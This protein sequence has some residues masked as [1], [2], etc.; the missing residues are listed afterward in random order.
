MKYKVGDKL[1]LKIFKNKI[2]LKTE[3]LKKEEYIEDEFIIVAINDKLKYYTIIIHDNMYGWIINKFHIIYLD[4]PEK[5]MGKKFY[6]VF[7]SQL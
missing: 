7:E 2:Y 4:V 6:D 3:K 1:K 5:Y